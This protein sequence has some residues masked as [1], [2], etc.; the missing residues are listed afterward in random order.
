MSLL[1]IQFTLPATMPTA[2]GLFQF[3]L[4]H[5]PPA[6]ADALPALVLVNPFPEPAPPPTGAGSFLTMTRE[7]RVNRIATLIISNLDLPERI[8]AERIDASLFDTENLAERAAYE[9]ALKRADVAIGDDQRE[10]Q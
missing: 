2:H 7:Q 8:I 5:S 10:V 4:I 3:S 1:A 6:S 9:E